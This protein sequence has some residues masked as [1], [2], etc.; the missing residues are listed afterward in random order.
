[1]PSQHM[2]GINCPFDCTFNKRSL[3]RNNKIGQHPHTEDKEHG[4]VS[5]SPAPN[6]VTC[7]KKK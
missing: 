1:V 5:L 6:G 2:R 4:G 3:S 7:G